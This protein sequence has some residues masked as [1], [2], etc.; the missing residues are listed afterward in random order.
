MQKSKPYNGIHIHHLIHCKLVAIIVSFQFWYHV[1]WL[2]LSMSNAD[3][4]KKSKQLRFLCEYIFNLVFCFWLFYHTACWAI[5]VWLLFYKDRVCKT[6]LKAKTDAFVSNYENDVRNGTWKGGF[7]AKNLHHLQ[8]CSQSV[9]Q[10]SVYWISQSDQK[11]TESRWTASA[12]A[13]DE[14]TWLTAKAMTPQNKVLIQG[15]GLHYPGAPSG[16]S[17]GKCDE[18]AF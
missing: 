6:S 10:C 2:C 16:K 17:R 3:C 14:Q 9:C 1:N 11:D 7:P 8:N 12:M 5:I 4:Y 15:Y 13:K 18:S